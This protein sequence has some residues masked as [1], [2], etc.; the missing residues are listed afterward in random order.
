MPQGT[1]TIKQLE[2]SGRVLHNI[3]LVTFHIHYLL[4]HFT[5]T[6]NSHTDLP[7][8]FYL[9]HV[10]AKQVFFVYFT[11]PCRVNITKNLIEVYRNGTKPDLE[12]EKGFRLIG[13]INGDRPVCF[14]GTWKFDGKKFYLRCIAEAEI[15]KVDNN[16]WDESIFPW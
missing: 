6:T 14:N 4:F 11:A 13:M 5:S 15:N 10:E 12:C 8:A 2:L 3:K 9:L 1:T 7:L 16:F